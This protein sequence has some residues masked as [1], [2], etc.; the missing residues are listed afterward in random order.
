MEVSPLATQSDLKMLTCHSSNCKLVYYH[1][2]LIESLLDKG[3]FGAV[4]KGIWQDVSIAIKELDDS[5]DP[6]EFAEEVWLMNQLDHPNIVKFVGACN[7]PKFC[8]L[9]E[10]I[11]G[12]SLYR[13]LHVDKK[14]LET[15]VM[16]SLLSDIAK[17]LSYLHEQKVLHRDLKSKVCS[18]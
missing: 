17:G 3:Q 4:Y 8:I 5:T 6:K 1:D 15:E 14:Q 10:F 12:G 2:L 7:A 16:T 13:Y 9:M 18:R 11:E